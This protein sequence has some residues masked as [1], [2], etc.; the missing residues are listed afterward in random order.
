VVGG[1]V[2]HQFEGVAA[3]DERLSLGNQAFQFDRLDL[4]AV[5]FG[6]EAA[7]RL[8]VDIEFAFDSVASAVEEVDGRPEEIGEIGFEPRVFQGRDQGVEDV[9]DGAAQDP[10]VG[11]RSWIRIVLKGSI[12][13]ELK[14]LQN[15]RRR[16]CGVA[17]FGA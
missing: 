15:A 1:L 17:G 14:F 9:G 7:L 3:F 13:V 6:L 8:L 16:R 2:A 5:L 10:C 12:A 4:G 11:K